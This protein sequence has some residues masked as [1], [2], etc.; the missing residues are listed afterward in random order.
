[1]KVIERL[2]KLRRYVGAQEVKTKIKQLNLFPTIER[3]QLEE[4][5]A[6]L[7]KE[8]LDFRAFLGFRLNKAEPIFRWFRFKE[9]FS[10]RLVEEIL[11]SEWKFPLRNC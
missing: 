10:Q 6:S 5:Y 7:V 4:K 2:T 3:G 9:A 8:R 1:L 11:T